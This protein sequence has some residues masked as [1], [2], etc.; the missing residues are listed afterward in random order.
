V[1]SIVLLSFMALAGGV[2]LLC[3]TES[4]GFLEILFESASAF[5][6]VGL[7]LGLSG[8]QTELTAFG[9]V[10]ITVLMF[11]GRLGPITLVLTFGQMKERAVYRYP[12][13]R[14]LVG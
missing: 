14:V 2:F 12:D 4:A 9:R 7:S 5:G 8:P 3:V 1:V 6:T 10:V 11:T 13:A